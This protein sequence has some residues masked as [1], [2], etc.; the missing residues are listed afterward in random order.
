MRPP[1]R[2]TPLRERS[3]GDDRPVADSVAPRPQGAWVT[4]RNQQVARVTTRTSPRRV[5]VAAQV[6]VVRSASPRPA[7]SCS[8][9]A[10]CGHAGRDCRG[11]R[12]AGTSPMVD[13]KVPDAASTPV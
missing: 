11:A 4:T 10:G 9:T 8:A 5:T 6:A 7:P 13:P 12:A 3:I 1:P 2:F